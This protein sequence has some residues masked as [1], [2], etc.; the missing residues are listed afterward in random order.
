MRRLREII[1]PSWP[2]L[3]IGRR[4]P[5][6]LALV[7][8]LGGTGT[9]LAVWALRSIEQDR[10]AQ[11]L[12][13]HT[14]GVTGAVEGYLRQYTLALQDLAAAAAAQQDL[15]AEDF[16][17]ITAPLDGT[18]LPGAS[19]VAFVVPAGA[20]QVA[21]LQEQWRARTGPGLTLQPTAGRS[22]HLFVVLSRTLDGTRP[23]LG[24]DLTGSAQAAGAIA[25][26]RQSREITVSSSYVLLKDRDLP[27]RLQQQAFVFAAGV[28]APAGSAD[29]GRLRGF[30]ILAMRA[31]DFLT[32]TI[33]DVAG[34]AA[35]VTLTDTSVSPPAPV[36]SWDS[37]RPHRP[38]ARTVDVDVPARTWRLM[39]T[40][41]DRLLD[42]TQTRL[43]DAAIA[44]GT[45]VTALL[46]ALVGLVL[47]SRARILRKVD[48][49]TAALQE[50]IIRRERV[51]AELRQRTGELR[52]FAGVVAHDL[53]S[54][55]ST[56]T[57]YADVLADETADVLDA[58]Q[59]G[60]LGRIRTGA[61]RM[62]V[63]IDD[64]LS[65]AT[66]DS[67]TVHR[68]PVDLG[69]LVADIVT[70]R[71]APIAGDRPYIEIGPLPTVHGDPGMLRQLLDNL[72]GNAIK[73][74]R[75]G[76]AAHIEISSRQLGDGSWR[77]DVADH[78]IGIPDSQHESV[79]AAF[80]RASGSEGY[81]GTG[82]GLAICHRI[83]TRH[84]GT[85][86]V[87]PNTGG[88]SR[89]HFTLPALP[90][91]GTAPAADTARSPADIC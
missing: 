84:G 8:L 68:S 39:V 29:A 13:E 43:D 51:E 76:R 64:L 1:A 33:G 70:E 63:L 77:I 72:I 83:V 66:A 65:Y 67:S 91:T 14:R 87:T 49:A 32:D 42:S 11:A 47:A 58:D 5:A 4:A 9:G 37:G 88:G 62:R 44:V 18:R 52:G 6:V 10:A 90:P 15:R 81:P 82:L 19:G 78:G 28:W 59:R 69:A 80:T 36:A 25:L 2:R 41:T 61:A 55:L 73:Y 16:A 40:A 34:R 75:Y 26:A 7:V 46:T 17:T 27:V 74:T 38:A 20:A 60:L 50:D 86:A 35:A 24:R 79:F 21:P 85:I 3:S 54:P 12:D 48:E 57:A 56:I 30:L 89:F 31:G 53:R 23:H 71:L 45:V 22:E